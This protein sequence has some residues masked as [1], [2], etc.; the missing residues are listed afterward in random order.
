MPKLMPKVRM[1]RCCS[2]DLHRGGLDSSPGTVAQR[3]AVRGSAQHCAHHTLPVV[4]SGVPRLAAGAVAS[5][6]RRGPY[7][8]GRAPAPRDR[9]G[10]RAAR[11]A[12]RVGAVE[13]VVGSNVIP[14]E[15]S[16]IFGIMR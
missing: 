9:P 6:G 11:P 4:R 5:C 2:Y 7:E 13:S 8:A 15:I 1:W 12:T 3:T 16:A 10:D 14:S